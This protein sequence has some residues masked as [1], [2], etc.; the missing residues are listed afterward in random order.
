MPATLYLVATPIG[1]LADITL[2]AIETLRNVDVIAC[3]D[4]RH[5]RK[6]LGHLGITG[7]LV[8]Y[9]EHNETARAAEL[10]AMLA[11][12]KSVAVV[13]DAGTPGINDPGYRI[14]R[15]AIQIGARVESVP[16]PAAFVAAVVASGL[17]TDAVYFGG[18]L[19]ARKGERRSRLAEASAIPATLVFYE[20]PHRVASA[21]ADCLDVLG[22]R[23]AVIAR[24]LTKL[25]EEFIRGSL[26]ELA[27]RVKA[28]PVKGEIVLLIDRG[29]D[30]NA[31]AY[32]RATLADRVA[33]LEAAGM[34]R[35]AALK[36]AA[37]EFGMSRSEAYRRLQNSKK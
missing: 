21:L 23:Q 33:E 3:E 6:L 28:T 16:G 8:S 15:A 20:T 24:E 37:K 34:D 25:Y 27:A 26:S 5:T 19:P 30:I 12:G 9:H 14:V 11:E 18:F 1:N 29:T 32:D 10:A 36:Q 17:A 4:T 2:R 35:K 31:R 22:D 7:R 13:S